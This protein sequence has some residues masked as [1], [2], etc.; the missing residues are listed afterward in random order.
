MGDNTLGKARKNQASEQ[1]NVSNPNN[2]QSKPDLPAN[3]EDFDITVPNDPDINDDQQLKIW[4]RKAHN[5]TETMRKHIGMILK[6]KRDLLASQ[7]N[8]SGNGWQQW[9]KD[10]CDFTPRTANRY[11]KAYDADDK[12]LPPSGGNDRKPIQAR[13][14]F[15]DDGLGSN[16]KKA[17]KVKKV[18]RILNQKLEQAAREVI[19]GL[20][21]EAE[22]NG[23]SFDELLKNK[24]NEKDPDDDEKNITQQSS[25]N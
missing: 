24:S 7:G 20:Q 21:K 10:N 13:V 25:Q 15:S 4:L 12:G 19:E 3:G 17:K 8:A 14:E 2:Q 22:D 6:A 1:L 9:V 16:Y 5:A 18:N 11:I 23:W